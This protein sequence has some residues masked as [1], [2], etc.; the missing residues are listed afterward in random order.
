MAGR[1][2][3]LSSTDNIAAVGGTLGNVTTS[4]GRRAHEPIVNPNSSASQSPRE[5]APR[6]KNEN[7]AK[8]R[9]ELRFDIKTSDKIYDDT[10]RR[11]QDTVR[12]RRRIDPRVR[13]RAGLTLPHSALSSAQLQNEHFDC[14]ITNFGSA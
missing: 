10:S 8:C 9:C 4:D 2:L 12:G 3:V 5:R 13:V 11:R 14:G 7:G 6:Y 1:S